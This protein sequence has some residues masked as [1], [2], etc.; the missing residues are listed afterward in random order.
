MKD[1]ATIIFSPS[2]QS[3]GNEQRACASPSLQADKAVYSSCLCVCVCV[4]VF[5]CLSV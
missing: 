5:V 4:G 2:H 3:G 1:I